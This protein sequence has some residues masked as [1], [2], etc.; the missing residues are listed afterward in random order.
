MGRKRATLWCHELILDLREIERRVVDLKFLGV[1]GTTGTQASFLA[2]FDG[3]HS[4]VQ[5]LDRRVAEAFEFE[6]SYPVSGQTYSRKI[7]SQNTRH[8]LSVF[9]VR[10]FVSAHQAGC[11][12]EQPR[13][14]CIALPRNRVRAGS[15]A[16]D[17]SRHQSQI[18][19]RLCGANTLMA[20]IDAHCPPERSPLAFVNRSGKSLQLIGTQSRFAGHARDIEPIDELRELVVILG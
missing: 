19:H 18:D 7:D 15:G 16:A 12:A 4:K 5:E 20:L 13:T 8:F 6:E 2:L 9:F 3:D 17:V 1:K 11:V 14:H 10:E